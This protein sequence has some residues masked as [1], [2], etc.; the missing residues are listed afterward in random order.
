MSVFFK[1]IYYLTTHLPFN[2]K[3]LIPSNPNG[4]DQPHLFEFKKKKTSQLVEKQ[5][6]HQTSNQN[7]ILVPSATSNLMKQEDFVHPL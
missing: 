6:L 1:L 4:F 3:K 5:Q 2:K 7:F